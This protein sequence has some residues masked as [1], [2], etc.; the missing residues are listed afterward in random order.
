MNGASRRLLCL[1][2]GMLGCTGAWGAPDPSAAPSA[3]KACPNDAGL[4]LPAGFCASIF[5]DGIGHARPMVAAPNG[6]LYVNTWSGRYYHNEPPHAGGFL[7]ALQDTTGAGKS[8]V[9]R[10]FGETVATGGAGGTGIGL[11]QGALYAEINDK[12]VRYALPA[13]SLVPPGRSETI[14]SGLPLGGDHPMHPFA[15]DADGHLYVDVATATNAC[16]LQNRTAGSPGADPCE[17]LK[18]RGRIWRYDA[19]VPNQSFT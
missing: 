9:N 1:L 10:R 5:A 11:Y 13:G 12:I 2:L 6:V 16:Q 7:I 4:K 18:T 8:N 14:V 3:E 19:N 15:L 17:E